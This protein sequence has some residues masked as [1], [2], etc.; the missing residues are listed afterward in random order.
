MKFFRIPA[1]I[2]LSL[3]FSSAITAQE[4]IYSKYD[5][6]D[7]RSGEFAVAGKVGDKLYVYRGSSEGYYLDAYDDGMRRTATVVLDFIPRR[8]FGTKFITYPGKII[9][10]YQVTESSRVMQYAAILDESGRLV[11]KPQ[12][13]DAV[14]ASFLGGRSGLYS[15]AVSANK[16]Q[17]VVYGAGAKGAEL[18]TRVVWLDTAMNIRLVKEVGFT[19]DNDISFGDGIVNDN[20]AFFLPVY[21]AFGSRQYADRLWL[22]AL[23]DTSKGFYAAEMPLR[24]L[25]ASGTYMEISNAGDR[26]YVGGFFSDKK[27]GNFEGIHYTYYDVHAQDFIEFKTISFSEKMRN[28]TGERNKKRAFND[29]QVRQLIVRND[30]GFVMIAED[31]F[32][33]TRNN[34]NQGFGYYSWYYP[35]MGASIREYN[36]G[37]IFAI[38]CNASGEAEWADFIRKSQYSQ[39]DGGLFSSYALINTGG[40]LGFVFNDFSTTRSKIQ[41]AS[42]DGDGKVLV[43]SVAGVKTDEPDWLP[44]SGKQ[45]SAKEFIVPCL[46]RNQICFAKV[47]F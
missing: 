38:S 20:G 29:F 33:S 47:V 10:L 35:S 25:F 3:F 5:K 12:E 21:T 34:Y 13:I 9:V 39:E 4:V 27:N 28:A 15:Y 8:S 43:T 42:L 14:K 40:S 26:I 37:D 46:K 1:L 32:I 41:L 24:D 7:F 44:K 31:F 16:Q 2:F 17:I 23:S 19:A 45:V 6:F 36:Y 18:S 11:K 22:L 30:G